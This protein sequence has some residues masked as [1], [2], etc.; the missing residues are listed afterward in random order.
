MRPRHG[1]DL[2]GLLYQTVE[3]F[4]SLTGLAAVES[5][6]EFVEVIVKVFAAN[7]SLMRS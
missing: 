5:K 4:S 3:Q 2:H 7:G 6:R 1:I